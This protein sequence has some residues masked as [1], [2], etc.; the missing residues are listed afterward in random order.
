MRPSKASEARSTP[1]VESDAVYHE[2][3]R[4]IIH[5][6]LQ[7]GARLREH[8][9]AQE[10]GI[11]RTPIRRILDRLAHQGLVTVK[12]G[13][14]ASVSTVDLQEL[15]EVW[16]LR[17]KIAELVADFVRLPAE[18]SVLERLEQF[19][20]RLEAVTTRREVAHLYDE[21]HRAMLEVMSNGPLRAIYDQLYTQT[22]RVW[23]QMLPSLPLEDE[24][25][26][27]RD[28]IQVSLEACVES[29]ADRLAE[30]RT[31]HM[32]MLLSR[33]NEAL[34]ITPPTNR[35]DTENHQ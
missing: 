26:A 20:V 19:L 32:H 3:R 21:Y 31:K 15:R 12:P 4:R 24:I 29:S 27:I 30:V 1:P 16:A 5:L 7:A 14:G 2:L 9:L 34:I 17:L 8:E 28:E 6:E 13:S 18:P 11:S 25:D 10:F 22:F 33:F 23:A 35:R